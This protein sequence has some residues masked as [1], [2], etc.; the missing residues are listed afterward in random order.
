MFK[1][2]LLTLMLAGLIYAAAPAAVAQDAPNNDQQAPP[3]GGPQ[4]QGRT[5]SRM[6]PA[7]RAEMLTT[8]LNLTP[9]QKTKVL[10]IMKSDRSK[11]ESVRDDSSL[12]PQDRRAKM[13]DIRKASNGQIRALLDS[14]QQKKFDEMQA[15]QEQWMQGHHPGGEGMGA[16]PDAPQHAPEQK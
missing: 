13:M 11:I 5:R 7:R 1:Q 3:A 15:R 4:E 6:D 9:D 14:N 8:Q 12:S 10:D 2:C 16:P